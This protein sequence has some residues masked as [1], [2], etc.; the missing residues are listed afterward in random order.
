MIKENDGLYFEGLRS[1]QQGNFE[2]AL[3]FYSL[4]GKEGDTMALFAIATI[5]EKQYRDYEEAWK[6]YQSAK[7]QG[8]CS[9]MIAMA[10]WYEKG[11]WVSVDQ[12]EAIKLYNLAAASGNIAA[13]SKLFK[14]YSEGVMT[15]RD[16]RLAVFW[17][18]KLAN[19]E[20]K[21]AMVLL[22][23]SYLYG[24]GGIKK[25]Y[26]MALYWHEKSAKKIPLN[27]KIADMYFFGDQYMS[28]DCCWKF[29]IVSNRYFL[30][31]RIIG[32]IESGIFEKENK[33]K[34][35]TK[36]I[37]WYKKLSEANVDFARGKLS[38]LNAKGLYMPKD[39][40]K[41]AYWYEL[42]EERDRML[43]GGD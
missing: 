33:Y 31:E 35:I 16:E 15:E 13:W 8:S 17:L 23:D 40:E 24:N 7:D 11:I 25:D 5:Y 18:K 26:E 32:R 4:A 12:E 37:Y 42:S 1:E 38:F 22:A 27:D 2:R 30:S 41:A 10:H 43:W 6:W 19:I 20:N 3:L 21:F 34:N 39:A 14:I 29:N 28:S 9:A 36:A